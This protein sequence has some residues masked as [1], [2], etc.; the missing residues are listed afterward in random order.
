MKMPIILLA[1]S[2]C[3]LVELSNCFAQTVSTFVT[4]SGLNGPSG[5][6]LDSA[7][8]L[9]V[10]NYAGGNGM[11][12]LKVNPSAQV[13][14]ADSFATSAMGL[15]IDQYQ[16]MYVTNF[17]DGYITK[18][19]ASGNKSIVYYHPGSHPTNLAFD[20]S[21]NMFVS[22]NSGALYKMATDGTLG[23]CCADLSC[24]QG[25]AFD[26]T[27]NLFV[28]NYLNGQIC[29]ITPD[30]SLSVFATVPNP[31]TAHLTHLAIG[32]SGSLYVS[33]YSHNKIYKISTD[34]TA[35]VLAGT[36]MAG[37]TNG[38][39]SHATFDGPNGIAFTPQGDLI[40]SEYNAN[41]IRKIEGAETVNGANLLNKKSLI[42]LSIQSADPVQ[43]ITSN[44]IPGNQLLKI[45]NLSGLE[46]LTVVSAQTE[47]GRHIY[48]LNKN[49]LSAGIYFAVLWFN[50]SLAATQ[51][52]MV[53]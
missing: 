53:N 41:R 32:A 42:N 2:F 12:I 27:G 25:L 44:A 11:G 24:P 50:N 52:F 34:G 49:C 15:C 43:L 23:I 5:L 48:P 39:A 28:A 20:A 26:A 10:A 40:V 14:V 9:C 45:Y 37:G 46:V 17:D 19:D 47:A 21:G 18:T 1:L 35:S 16:N 29:K 4:D 36:G 13:S 51:K 31:L 38:P 22:D 7:Q 30:G 6:A 3:L 33:A 8:N